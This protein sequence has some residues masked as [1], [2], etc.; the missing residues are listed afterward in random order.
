ML[1]AVQEYGILLSGCSSGRLLISDLSS[2]ALVR[3]IDTFNEKIVDLRACWITGDI[4]VATEK[5]I[6]VFTINGTPLGNLVSKSSKILL[7]LKR[8][9]LIRQCHVCSG[10][11]WSRV[12]ETAHSFKWP[13]RRRDSSVGARVGTVALAQFNV[14]V[15]FIKN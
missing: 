9:S 6:S 1:R 11:S 12:G 4:F 7:F 8:L 5:Q 14:E 15:K 2:Y 3:L 10:A 13:S